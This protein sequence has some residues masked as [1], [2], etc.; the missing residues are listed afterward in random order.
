MIDGKNLFDQQ[1][2]DDTKTS[3]NIINIA[4]GKGDDYSW[5]FVRLSLFQ[6]KL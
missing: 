4:T 1:I 6:R 2:N 5:L 3:E